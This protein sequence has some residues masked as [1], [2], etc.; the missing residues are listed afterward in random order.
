MS[1]ITAMAAVVFAL[2]VWALSVDGGKVPYG[3]IISDSQASES[4]MGMVKHADGTVIGTQETVPEEAK[5]GKT[6]EEK[7]EASSPASAPGD[8]RPDGGPGDQ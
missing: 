2:M 7:D 1:I 3:L 6:K 4:E 5:P 8:S